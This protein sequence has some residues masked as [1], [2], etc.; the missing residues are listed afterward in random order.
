MP[1]GR[2]RARSWLR[3]TVAVAVLGLS[4]AWLSR[5]IDPGELGRALAG[6]DYRLVALMTVAHL[7]LFLSI[8]AWRWQVVLAPL[9]RVPLLRLYRYC[10]AGCAVTNL[11]PMRAGL[12]TRVLLLRRDGVPVPGGVGSLAVEE[13]SNAVVLGAIC[14][15]VPFLLDLGPRVRLTVVGVTAGAAIAL[16]LLVALAAAGRVS[17]SALLRRVS[18]GVHVL[19]RGRGAGLVLA[20]TAAMWAVDLGQIALAMMAVGVKASYVGVALVLLFVNL[21]NAFPATP[22]QLGLFEAAATAACVAVGAAPE[23][24]V[25]VGVLYHVMQFVPETVLGLAALGRDVLGR[26]ARAEVA[27]EGAQMTSRRDAPGPEPVPPPPAGRPLATGEWL[28]HGPFLAHLVVTRRCNLACAYCNEYDTASAPVPTALV[29]E[30]LAALRRL[31]T[32]MICLTGGEPTMHPDVVRLVAHAT[33]L[34]FRRRQLLTNGFRLKEELIEA[35]NGA[36]L[37]DLQIS[38]DGVRQT[39]TTMKVLDRLRDKLDLL[40]RTARFQVVVSAVVGSAPAAEALEVVRFVREAGLVPRFVLLHDGA[41]R[42]R[43]GPEDLVAFDQVK[44]AVGRGAREAGDYRQALLDRGAAPFRCRAGA[45]YL[46]VDEFGKAHWCSQ[47]TALFSKDLAEY[48][49]E[50]LARQFRTP[51]PCADQCTVGCARSA[52][53]YDGWRGQGA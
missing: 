14:L 27:P 22:G 12:A 51:K 42:L 53:A 19:G 9:R 46:Y 37:T 10:L 15:P 44:R 31:R 13:I 21:T 11:V 5:R 35:L 29:M 17:G 26:G 43:L 28:H 23:K 2:A 30:R 33:Q 47:T 40:A 6:A 1:F 48:G 18:E 16:G 38:V 41:G 7:A 8:K 50:E 34:G 4:L 36:G 24:G 32:W 39:P 45:R 25:A 52:S 3:W 49:S 20:L